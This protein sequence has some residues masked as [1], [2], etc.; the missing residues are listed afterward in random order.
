[1]YW[2]SG[3]VWSWLTGRSGQFCPYILAVRAS[4]V[5]IYWPFGPVL[6]LCTGPLGQFGPELL[7]LRASLVLI[8]PGPSFTLKLVK[9]G[10][11][12]HGNAKNRRC[13]IF[14]TSKNGVTPNIS[15]PNWPNGP[16]HKDKTGPKGQYIST[17]LAISASLQIEA[18][19][20]NRKSKSKLET[21]TRNWYLKSKL[22]TLIQNSNLKIEI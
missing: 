19:L 17:K 5:L 12:F 4:F 10:F 11:L 22:E 21:E 2:P 13:S 16:V 7:A 20:R 6:S 9:T 15:G 14:G 3:P 8:F 18:R 1:M